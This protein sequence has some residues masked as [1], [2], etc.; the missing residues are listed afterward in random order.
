MLLGGVDPGDEVRLP[1]TTTQVAR[2]PGSLA[3]KS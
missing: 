2:L 1:P 3:A